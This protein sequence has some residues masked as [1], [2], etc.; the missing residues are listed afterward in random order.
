MVKNLSAYNVGALGSIPGLERS[1]GE[2]NGNPL[3]YSCL[4]N[5]INRGALWATVQDTTE[6]LNTFTFNAGKEQQQMDIS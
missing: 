5:S 4:D 3:Q 6:Q 2:G 1:L